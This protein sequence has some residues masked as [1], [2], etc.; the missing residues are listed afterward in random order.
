MIKQLTT[1]VLGVTA[2]MGAYSA[3]ALTMDEMKQPGSAVTW[4]QD[5]DA[6][7]ELDVADYLFNHH[8]KKEVTQARID[9]VEQCLNNEMKAAYDDAKATDSN[10]PS[11]LSLLTKCKA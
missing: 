11:L 1:A 4:Y 10:A 7:K 5:D 3:N 6:M 2:L 8:A 9:Q